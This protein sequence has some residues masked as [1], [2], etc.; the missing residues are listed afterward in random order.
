MSTWFG[1]SPAFGAPLPIVVTELRVENG[2][3]SVSALAVR[4]W[5]E[6]LTNGPNPAGCCSERCWEP[7][8]LL[9]LLQSRSAVIRL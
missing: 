9:H 1:S 5:R 7:V 4:A 3:G 8:R 2:Q 6:M